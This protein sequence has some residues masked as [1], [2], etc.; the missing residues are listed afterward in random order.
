M[1]FFH[2]LGEN[3]QYGHKGS[4]LTGRFLFSLESALSVKGFMSTG[5][6]MGAKRKIAY[7]SS[8]KRTSTE[9]GRGVIY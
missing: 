5:Q 1:L 4:D 9:F 7:H 6:G 3:S 8:D 2:R